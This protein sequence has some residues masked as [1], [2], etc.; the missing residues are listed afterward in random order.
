MGEERSVER[1]SL[2]VAD[3]SMGIGDVVQ[4]DTVKN[5]AM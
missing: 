3:D 4:I 2:G 5:M 1:K